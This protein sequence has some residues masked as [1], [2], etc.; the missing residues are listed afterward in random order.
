[1]SANGD[2]NSA[3]VENKTLTTEENSEK[4]ETSPEGIASA[5]KSVGD[6]QIDSCIAET[7]YVS[8]ELTNKD[9]GDA[10]EEI[11][12]K[13]LKEIEEKDS[14]LTELSKDS[15]KTGDDKGSG[16]H[17]ANENVA[18]VNP[19]KSLTPTEKKTDDGQKNLEEPPGSDSKDEDEME[20]KWDDDEAMEP[21]G[22]TGNDQ[23]SP[24]TEEQLLA[25][26]SDTITEPLDKQ[27]ESNEKIGELSESDKNSNAKSTTETK[28]VENEFLENDINSETMQAEVD[29]V[30]KDILDEKD[31]TG[32]DTEMTVTDK[33]DEVTKNDNV[34]L[35]KNTEQVIED[36]SVEFE[37]NKQTKNTAFEITSF[38]DIAMD[39]EDDKKKENLPQDKKDGDLPKQIEIKEEIIDKETSES[40]EIDALL[41][42]QL[43]AE[44]DVAELPPDADSMDAVDADKERELLKEDGESQN[45]MNDKNKNGN[46]DQVD[47]KIERSEDIVPDEGK[48]IRIDLEL[49]KQEVKEIKKEV[50]QEESDNNSQDAIDGNTKDDLIENTENTDQSTVQVQLE[51]DITIPSQTERTSHNKEPAEKVD[52]TENLVTNVVKEEISETVP[53][54]TENNDNVAIESEDKSEKLAE[55]ENLDKTSNTESKS[56]EKEVKTIKQEPEEDKTPTAD[57]ISLCEAASSPAPIKT[58]HRLNRPD[59]M[60][61]IPTQELLDIDD[62]SF[63]L[64]RLDSTDSDDEED[65]SD[66]APVVAPAPVREESQVT[67]S[68]NRR[69]MVPSESI[70]DSL[71]K[72][73]ADHA[74]IVMPVEETI[75]VSDTS[76]QTDIEPL[77]PFLFPPFPGDGAS[78]SAAAIASIAN[79]ATTSKDATATSSKD[80]TTSND[81]TATS[82]NDATDTNV[83]TT[84]TASDATVATTA[85]DAADTATASAAP[86][87]AT[88]ANEMTPD[89]SIGVPEVSDSLGLLAESSGRVMEDDEEPEDDDDG[90]DDEDF[91]QDESSNQVSAEQSEDSNPPASEP[92]PAKDQDGK[93]LDTPEPKDD[94]F[95]FTATEP[96]NSGEKMDVDNESCG[97][98]TMELHAE[99]IQEDD[100]NSGAHAVPTMEDGPGTPAVQTEQQRVT[101]DQTDIDTVKLS[102]TSD[103]EAEETTTDVRSQTTE[104]KETEDQQNKN[105][106]SP[107]KSPTTKKVTPE[108]SPTKS[109]T[110]SPAQLKK[111]AI[112]TQ[113]E[114]SVVNIVDLE[115]S[116]SSEDEIREIDRQLEPKPKRLKQEDAQQTSTST[117]ADVT[118]VNIPTDIE[119]M[120]NAAGNTSAIVTKEGE[121]VVS[122]VPK[123]PPLKLARLNTSEVSIK[124]ASATEPMVIPV[125]QVIE[126]QAKPKIGLEVF[127]LDSD[128]DESCPKE[129]TVQPASD[130]PA[131]PD[132]PR[133]CVNDRCPSG[134]EV[135]FQPAG[136]AV[137]AYYDAPRNKRHL[138]CQPCADVVLAMETKLVEGIKNFT[139]LLDLDMSKN[140][141]D[142][143]KISDSESEDEDQGPEEERE[144]IGEKGAKF[145][146][147]NLAHYFNNTWKKYNMDARLK[148]TQTMLDN[149]ID[150]LEKDSKEID[151]MLNECQVA[152]DKLRN[153]LYATFECRRKELTPLVLFDMPDLKFVALEAE[154][155][156]LTPK[157]QAEQAETQTRLAKR[158]NSLS[159]ELPAKKMAI[160]LGYT[161]LEQE[162]PKEPTPTTS[163]TVPDNKID[164]DKDVSVVKL[165]A[166]SAPADLPPPGEISR[167]PLRVSMAVYAMKNAFGPWLRGRILEILPK[168]SAGGNMFSLCRVKFD[169]KAKAGG[170]ILP[171]RCI[172]YS[173]PADVRMTIGTRLIALF[174]DSNKRESYYSGVVAEIPNPVNNY[175]Y[176]VFFDDGYAQYVQHQHTRLVCESSPLVWEEVHPFSREFVREYLVAYPER[177]MVRL[178]EGQNLKT[179]WNGKWWSSRVTRVD[180]S[181]AQVVFV[182][183]GRRE[184]IYRGST[185]LAPL[186]LELRAAERHR[187]RPMPRS[188]A[189][190]RSNM[191]YVEYTRSDEQESRNRQEA[192][193]QQQ[194]QHNEEMIRRQR[195][196]A[197]K[198]TSIPAPPP[199]PSQPST[200]AVTSRVVYYTPKNAVKPY[201][202]VPHRCSPKCQRTDILT[203]RELRTYNPLAKPLL[204]GWERQ[205]VRF[206]GHK[207]VMYRAPCGRRLRSMAELHRYLQDTASDLPVDLFDFQPA[208]HC[209]AEFVLNKCLVGKKDLSHGKEN[210]PVPCVNYYDESLPE[211]CSYNTERTPTA[212][213]PLNLDPDFLCGC[214]CTDDCQDKTKCACWKMTLEGARTIGLDGP[215]VGYVYKR[216]PEPLPSGIYECNSRCKCKHT[217]LNRVAQHPLQLKLQVF[218]T[219]TRGWGI[220]AL[221]DVPKGAFLCVYAGNLLTDAT[222]NLDGLNEGDEYLAE[223]DYIEVVEQMKEGYEED[224]PEIDKR[225]D[226]K[227]LAKEEA[228]SEEE[229]LS[230]SSE[231]DNASKSDKE[232]DDFRPGYIGLGVMEFNKR[233]RKRDKIKKD[234]DETASEDTKD[235]E[236]KEEKDSKDNFKKETAKDDD[237][238]ITISDDE[239]VREPARFMAQAGMGASEFISK[240]KSVRT[241]FGKDE[242]CYIMDAKVQGNIGRYL[243]HS[244]CPNVFVQNVFVDTHD[245]RFPWVAFFALS[246]IKAGTELTWNYNY[247]VGS[248]PGKVLYCYCGAPNCRGRLL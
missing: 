107:S 188:K 119:I 152:T 134:P 242:A 1:M 58:N 40:K 218:K 89:T 149:E 97:F 55:N 136:P 200:D 208:T 143:V 51:P 199:P 77:P 207:E 44:T 244:C 224:I 68:M 6:T 128:E 92:E 5:K 183:D 61:E 62:L 115:E 52:E 172:A 109:F 130:P 215:N 4:S 124:T 243:N 35:E 38:T 154:E 36:T 48:E 104:Q 42:D 184:W 87:S 214:D 74:P 178:H 205:I 108:R 176:L 146:E 69:N 196:V 27:T 91:D 163:I 155:P 129:Q 148:E 126:Q 10:G 84:T 12:N 60:L 105:E 156:S 118:D 169:H 116:S 190:P 81:A 236:I 203:L 37:S 112:T 111:L 73:F 189:Q 29:T 235:K 223:L 122:G 78:T 212:G 175:R 173:E 30:I 83:A 231:E 110:Q 193:A 237:D 142:L 140:S 233:L 34:T 31:K 49:L 43:L 18:E 59:A 179:E 20:L 210:V 8:K 227:E 240:Y 66:K 141:Q 246:H 220:R 144:R 71:E 226:K 209:L 204:S 17:T 90:D 3:D 181:L 195:A 171:A 57:D 80:A 46:T 145:L 211:F 15:H 201:K 64:D 161:P 132:K 222:A 41:E 202:M 174:K 82:S 217:C 245:P 225:L 120:A 234:T 180:A 21:D 121:V 219:L 177:P 230:S 167:P 93:D 135:G 127:S 85:T 103:N 11:S 28:E 23:T 185:R 247:D 191:P 170:K 24:K 186:Y 22:G 192:Q 100:S 63:G 168:N 138:V 13:T 162:Q 239:E 164:D 98:G 157:E 150:K 96:Q 88:A 166:E 56:S 14:N 86:S 75:Y 153:E 160:A 32:E 65:T 45:G 232:D 72:M 216:L 131:D 137:A 113:Q 76:C 194:E 39:T 165:S 229:A 114:S 2:K 238:C 206:K 228:G 101:S 159:N 47:V 54:N 123:P 241:L 139:P 19:E 182:G 50:K 198:S 99:T 213:V 16:D 53:E 147:E 95:T 158:R 70:E 79:D 25:D 102:D 117:S 151:A 67:E 197:K 106:K 94:Q 7:Q 33:P 9:S 221:N 26:P 187:P 125:T 133:Q 248:V